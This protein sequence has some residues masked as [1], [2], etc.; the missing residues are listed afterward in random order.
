MKRMSSRPAKWRAGLLAAIAAVAAAAASAL[1][2]L[3]AG[4]AP[5]IEE[6]RPPVEPTT[7]SISPSFSPDKLGADAIFKLSFHF[8]GGELGIPQPGRRSVLHLPV[9]LTLSA[10]K[11]ATCSRARLR[12]RGVK[13]CS[14]N[15]LIGRGK[16]LVEINYGTLPEPEEAELW[17]FIGP[18]KGA[19]PT[20][21]I[22]A[23]GE[24]P[25][26]R[27]VILTGDVLPDHPPYGNKLIV[28]IPP[29]PTV[30]LE[31]DASTISF[32]ITIGSRQTG[33]GHALAK[34]HIP[35]HCPAGG[36]PFLDEFT[37]ADGSTYSAHATSH[38]P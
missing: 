10:N 4:A 11:I 23:Q 20:I 6:V 13:G 5:P 17:A 2:G 16:A 27:R 28:N 14:R 22:L 36:F 24:T 21:V 15:S 30:P 32:S 9:G 18:F 8:G 37:F 29:I 7:V 38:C 34:V 19:N 35:K 3:A 25:L 26:E 31:P 1:P 33:P 12:A